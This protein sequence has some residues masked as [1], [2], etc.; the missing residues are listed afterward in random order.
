MD[1]FDPSQPKNESGS[2]ST[3]GTTGLAFGKG[4]RLHGKL[5]VCRRFCAF[6]VT[7]SSFTVSRDGSHRTSTLL[8]PVV[9]RSSGLTRLHSQT[10]AVFGVTN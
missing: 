10:T 4:D 2:L 5:V 8:T 6:V 9:M 1:R 7:D 3:T